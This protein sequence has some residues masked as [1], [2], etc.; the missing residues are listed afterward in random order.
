LLLP[1]CLLNDVETVLQFG[2]I[3][4][5]VNHRRVIE[6]EIAR[7][8]RQTPIPEPLNGLV[9]KGGHNMDLLSRVGRSQD[10]IDLVMHH[11]P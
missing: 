1:Y 10:L 8:V 7:G 3:D 2:I 5:S 9:H 6:E 11:G 4:F